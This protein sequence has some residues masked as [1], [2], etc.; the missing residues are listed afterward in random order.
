M[1]RHGAFDMTYL[2]LEQRLRLQEEHNLAHPQR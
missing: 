1:N 2:L